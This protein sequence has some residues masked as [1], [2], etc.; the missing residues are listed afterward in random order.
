M[1]SSMVSGSTQEGS[2][3]PLAF[4]LAGLAA[5]G[6]VGLILRFGVDVPFHDDWGVFVPLLAKLS[7]GDLALGDLTAPFAGHRVFFPKLIGITLLG[8]TGGDFRA[9]MYVTPLVAAVTAACIFVLARR[10]SGSRSRSAWVL[11]FASL[12]IFSPVH[13]HSWLKGYNVAL[14]L[15]AASLAV[16]LVA[17]TSR[18]PAPVR[19]GIVLFACSVS[20]FSC[21]AGVVVW[22]LVLPVLWAE[23]SRGRGRV[24]ALTAWLV[25]VLVCAG[26][27]LRNY[28]SPHGSRSLTT[29]VERPREALV[30]VLTA[31]GSPLASAFGE[32]EATRSLM[33]GIVLTAAFLTLCAVSW[34]ACRSAADLSADEGRDRR[35]ALLVWATFGGLSLL[36]ALA[37]ASGR[38]GR[39]VGAPESPRYVSLTVWLAVATVALAVDLGGRALRTAAGRRPSAM[40]WSIAGLLIVHTFGAWWSALPALEETRAR[41]LQGKAALTFFGVAGRSPG[42]ALLHRRLAEWPDRIRGLNEGG[43]L[44]PPMVAT[45]L[46]G[47]LAAEG[48]SSAGSVQVGQ[49]GGKLELTGEASLPG[50]SESPHALIVGFGL[51]ADDQR[52]YTLLM[53]TELRGQPFE[54]LG[55]G[56]RGGIRWSALIPRPPDAPQ[57]AV[58]SVWAYDARSGEAFPLNR[59]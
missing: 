53:P 23:S 19:V 28:A 55:E 17:A 24:A 25:V 50:R 30:F 21:A 56:D 36:S 8:L 22:V 18:L 45:A 16:A 51:T 59:L 35:R 7:A 9:L 13:W 38:I 26:L 52:V 49:Q 29:L 44:N 1:T 5:A 31:V 58:P 14:F 43:F 3:T 6:A 41:R 32:R 46:I 4:L 54:L 42:L 57:Y 11:F 2:R 33:C 39:E 34:R 47:D 15:P 20:T 27:F 10:T 40:E 12:L 48:A 37:V